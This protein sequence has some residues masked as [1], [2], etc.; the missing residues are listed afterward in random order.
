MARP[1]TK[2]DLIITAEQEFSIL[3]ELLKGMNMYDQMKDFNFPEAFLSKHEQKHWSRDKNIRDVLIHLYEWHQLLINWIESN[4]AGEQKDFLP[5]TYNWR[6][7]GEMNQ[8]FWHAHQSTSLA[9]AVEM[10]KVTHKR[11]MILADSFT[12]EELFVKKQLGW[13]GTSTLGSF[14]IANTS[15]HYRWAISKIKKHRQQLK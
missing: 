4:Q 2:Q 9:S 5:K 11:V 14:F 8:E 3:L 7:I 10:L 13:T 15:S 6:M 12:N 1:S